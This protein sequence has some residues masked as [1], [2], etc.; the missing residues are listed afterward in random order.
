M[1][2]EA[3]IAII[4][5]FVS[6][7]LLQGI[8]RIVVAHSQFRKGP[9]IFQSFY[10]FFKLM[11]K[12]SLTP[13]VTSPLL[14]NIAPIL[15]ASSMIVAALIVPLASSQPA[16]GAGDL[17]FIIY[18]LTLPP[19]ALVLGGSASGSPYGALGAARE[20][21]LLIAYE[22][23]FIISI[24]TV[25]IVAGTFKLGALTQTAYITVLPLAAI[26]AIWTLPAAAGVPPFDI[27]E[28]ETEIVSGPYIEYSGPNL[29]LLKL[30]QWLKTFL[31]ASLISAVF[32]G[33]TIYHYQNGLNFVIHFAIIAILVTIFIAFWQATT[34][35]TRVTKLLKYFW[36][37]PMVLAIADL[38][39]FLAGVKYM[40]IIS[41]LVGL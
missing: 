23:P 36:S 24:I 35:R 34:G 4:Y 12:E 8:R 11:S 13:N 5:A 9:S 1:I 38:V 33:T 19:I 3:F 10:D 2:V 30:G 25:A 6:A 21:A 18:L 14:F 37:I 15:S 27:P 16:V 7:L 22:T 39:L 20:V 40:T 26:A 41:R 17:I 28:A 29:A 32:F 31:Y